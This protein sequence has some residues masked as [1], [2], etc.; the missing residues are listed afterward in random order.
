VCATAHNPVIMTPVNWTKKDG[1]KDEVPCTKAVAIY[2]DVLG[3]V[4]RL[5]RRKE[6]YQRRK[7]PCKRMT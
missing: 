2:S 6:R 1:T 5:N 7:R 3:G 4:V